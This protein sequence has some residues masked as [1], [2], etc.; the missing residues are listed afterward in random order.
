MR[1]IRKY[2]VERPT[3]LR[4][5]CVHCEMTMKWY[6]RDRPRRRQQQWWWWWRCRRIWDTHD[7]DRVDSRVYIVRSLSLPAHPFAIVMVLDVIAIRFLW[8]HCVRACFCPNIKSICF[9]CFYAIYKFANCS[10]HQTDCRWCPKWIT[11][12]WAHIQII[13]KKKIQEKRTN[14]WTNT[15]W[16]RQW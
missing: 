1:K 15:Q 5:V 14:E 4:I 10:L 13:K 6:N 16:Q 8:A 2:V 7:I 12:H 3:H 9:S 11:A